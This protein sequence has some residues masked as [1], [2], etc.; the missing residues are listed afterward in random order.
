MRRI[1]MAI[2]NKEQ[3]K[4]IGDGGGGRGEERA[5]INK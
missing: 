4:C 5:P 3:I 1:S 2:N